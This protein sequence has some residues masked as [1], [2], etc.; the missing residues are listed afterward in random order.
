MK[1]QLNHR[2][3]CLDKKIATANL[4]KGNYNQFISIQLC[5]FNTIQNQCCHWTTNS[6]L[7]RKLVCQPA[8]IK[9]TWHYQRKW[10]FMEGA[11]FQCHTRVQESRAS[12]WIYCIFPF[13]DHNISII[14]HLILAV[15]ANNFDQKT[16][17][18]AQ[19]NKILNYG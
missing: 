2:S 7:W 1:G 8:Y 16:W 9:S 17:F 4:N 3:L 11:E 5:P 13:Q 12:L 19:F 14:F 18:G 10:S 15:K 6:A